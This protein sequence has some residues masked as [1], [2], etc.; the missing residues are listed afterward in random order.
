MR[1]PRRH[2]LAC[3]CTRA[4][5]RRGNF[6]PAYTEGPFVAAMAAVGI[7]NSTLR[8]KEP[9]VE[10]RLRASVPLLPLSL[11]L[12]LSL[13]LSSDALLVGLRFSCS[14]S[15]SLE[16]VHCHSIPTT[17]PPRSPFLLDL[18]VSTS[19]P[20]LTRATARLTLHSRAADRRNKRQITHRDRRGKEG[21][22]RGKYRIHRV[23]YAFRY[24]CL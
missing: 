22:L 18:C 24:Q 21:Y 5:T 2:A 13:S 20:P 6:G 9:K 16:R 3:E 12:S 19:S 17:A 7:S 23:R 4:R 8:V 14:V 11:P 1:A 10:T 15:F